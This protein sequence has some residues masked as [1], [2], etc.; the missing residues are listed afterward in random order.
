MDLIK[1]VSNLERT[2]LLYQG[3]S[4][5]KNFDAKVIKS[6]KEKRNLYIALDRTAFHPKSGGQPS[7]TGFLY[8]PNF[9]LRLKKCMF[10]SGVVI[11][12]GRM[13]EGEEDF[14]EVKGEIDWDWRYLLMRRHTAGHLLDGCLS[15]TT[16]IQVKTLDSWLGDPCYVG[17]AGEAPEKKNIVEVEKMANELISQGRDVIVDYLGLSELLK[18]AYEVPNILRLPKMETY[19]VVTIKGFGSIPCGGTHLKNISEIGKLRINGVVS[20]KESFRVY[21]DVS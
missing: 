14:L 18:R 20:N 1:F 13:L 19:R 3:N 17:Y 15:A 8:G 4:Y 11:H 7:D 21:F 6:T 2:K 16:K 12:F 5:L 9:K 10:K